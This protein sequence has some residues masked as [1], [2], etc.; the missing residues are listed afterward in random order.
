M[1]VLGTH[2]VPY[3][4]FHSRAQFPVGYGPIV[5]SGP[6]DPSDFQDQIDL[7]KVDVHA[8]TGHWDIFSSNEVEGLDGRCQSVRL[9]RCCG[10]PL[11]SGNVVIRGVE[12]A[13]Q[14]PGTLDN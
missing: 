6:D 7:E 8:D 4:Q 12:V 10:K 13:S 5:R 1:K 2:L 11:G 9:V 3:A 14:H